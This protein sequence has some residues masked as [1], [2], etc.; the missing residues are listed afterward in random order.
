MS[1][2]IDRNLLIKLI[3]CSSA[4]YTKLQKERMYISFVK[5]TKSILEQYA[6]TRNYRDGFKL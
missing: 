1:I 5:K 6:I 4:N 3:L 2:T